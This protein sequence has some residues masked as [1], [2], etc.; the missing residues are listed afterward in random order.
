M[1]APSISRS[2][3]WMP[4][5]SAEDAWVLAIHTPLWFVTFISALSKRAVQGESD[6][7]EVH[8]VWDGR[9]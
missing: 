9:I 7:I 5:T 2:V 6:P 3:L 4:T 8:R 1:Q